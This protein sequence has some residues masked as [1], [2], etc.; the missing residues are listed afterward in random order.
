MSKMS[1]ADVQVREAIKKIRTIQAEYE[2]WTEENEDLAGEDDET[3]FDTISEFD[4][5]LGEAGIE[6]ADLLEKLMGVGE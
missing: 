3:W 4:E 6:L 1:D 5:Q 2:A